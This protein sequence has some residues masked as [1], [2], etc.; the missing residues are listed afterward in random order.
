MSKA[1]NYLL[2]KLLFCILEQLKHKVIFY[3]KLS[4]HCS[5]V[6]IKGN[7]TTRQKKDTKQVWTVIWLPLLLFIRGSLPPEPSKTSLHN[8]W[9]LIVYLTRSYGMLIIKMYMYC[10]HKPSSFAV[11]FCMYNIYKFIKLHSCIELPNKSQ[12]KQIKL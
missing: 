5:W 1:F 8:L 10:I 6:Y 7:Y 2:C 12:L 3:F 11:V 9:L 4:K